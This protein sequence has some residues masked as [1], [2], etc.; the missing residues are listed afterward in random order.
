[1]IVELFDCI[2][3]VTIFKPKYRLT[4]SKKKKTPNGKM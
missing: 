1:M 4:V 2:R 3:P